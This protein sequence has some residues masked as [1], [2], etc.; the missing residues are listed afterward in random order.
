MENGIYCKWRRIKDYRL[1]QIG[2]SR[3]LSGEWVKN[4][5]NTIGTD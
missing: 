2:C 4:G 5:V 3:S 1:R